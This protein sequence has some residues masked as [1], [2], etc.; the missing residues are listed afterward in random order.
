MEWE[1]HIHAL[2]DDTESWV[3]NYSIRDAECSHYQMYQDLLY[4]VLKTVK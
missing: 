2:H 1:I 4:I 3:Y